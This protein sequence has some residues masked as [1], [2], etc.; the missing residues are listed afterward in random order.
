VEIV[1]ASPQ[2]EVLDELERGVITADE[3]IRRLSQ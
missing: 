3:A 1:K 2:E